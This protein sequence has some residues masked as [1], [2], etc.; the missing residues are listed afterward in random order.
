MFPNVTHTVLT[1]YDKVPGT[2]LFGVL[3]IV[4]LPSFLAVIIKINIHFHERFT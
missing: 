4:L 3:V 2:H 1:L